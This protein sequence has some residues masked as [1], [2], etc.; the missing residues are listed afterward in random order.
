[1]ACIATTICWTAVFGVSVSVM[2]GQMVFVDGCAVVLV[3]SVLARSH[4]QCMSVHT[5]LMH[6]WT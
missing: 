2:V 4:V 6:C 3:C 1:M 5:L